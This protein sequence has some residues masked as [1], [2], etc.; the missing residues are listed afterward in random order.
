MYPL[1]LT[2]EVTLPN[3]NLSESQLDFG[4][5][6]CGQCKIF[7]IRLSNPFPVKYA[8]TH[9][10]LFKHDMRHSFLAN[11]CEINLPFIFR[12]EWMVVM[13][14][15]TKKVH[16]AQFKTMCPILMNVKL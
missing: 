9:H 12:C 1:K 5:V 15:P 10:D 11:I 8:P 16:I 6:M 13:D 7:T 2:A 14:K 3:M 4:K